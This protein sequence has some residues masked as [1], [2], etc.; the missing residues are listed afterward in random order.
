MAIEGTVP[1]AELGEQLAVL[2]ILDPSAVHAVQDSLRRH[3]QL[4]SVVAFRA[5]TG[6]LQIIDGFKRLRAAKALSMPS[7]LVR[8]LDCD[9]SQAKAALR[10]INV[11]HR[12]SEL[13]D[14]WLVRSLYREDHLTQPAIGHLLQHDKSWVCRR[15]SLVERLDEE[16]QADV[17]LGLIAPR[18]AM[19]LARLPRGNQI[20]AAK[21]ATERAL[22]TH[23]VERLVLALLEAE[24]G[25]RDEILAH[26]HAD[27]S[28]PRR[29]KTSMP[30]ARNAAESAI[31]DAAQIHR[32]AGRLQ[33][34]LGE[35]PL[36]AHDKASAEVLEKSLANLKPILLA[37]VRTL[38]RVIDKESYGHLDRP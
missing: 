20:S 35:R 3:G 5:A 33:A 36:S 11:R 29:A 37:L 28:L 23:Q 18:A 30:R 12:L 8:E 9:S 26:A 1:T 16:V 14:A 27:G 10:S 6:E 24:P 19:A 31:L 17:R 2:R 21:V 13:E 32:V 4:T 34:R 15:L 7:L 25:A 38:D 22:T